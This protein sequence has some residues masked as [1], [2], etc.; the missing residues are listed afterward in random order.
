MTLGST[1]PINRS[2]KTKISTVG[3]FAVQAYLRER[4]QEIRREVRI[5]M[6][7][8]HHP[9]LPR[10]VNVV[11]F[12]LFEILILVQINLTVRQMLL[13][14]I[15]DIDIDES[16]VGSKKLFS[17]KHVWIQRELL[18]KIKSRRK[19]QLRKTRARQH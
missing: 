6:A 14:N 7:I 8:A 15:A 16:D 10:R 13:A 12:G 9:K 17:L 18:A 11:I 5:D 4:T 19:F 2:H 3:N 1:R